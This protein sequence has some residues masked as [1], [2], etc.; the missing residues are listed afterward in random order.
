MGAF[1]TV[2]N[3]SYPPMTKNFTT[4][5]HLN[6]RLRNVINQVKIDCYSKLVL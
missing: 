2:T 3:F 5:Y 1:P 4:L 6:A